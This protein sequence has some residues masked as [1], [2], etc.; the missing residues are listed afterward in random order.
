MC[1]PR[2][3]FLQCNHCFLMSWVEM[4]HSL[5]C[6]HR[7]FVTARRNQQLAELDEPVEV[8][9]IHREHVDD[10]RERVLHAPCTHLEIRESEGRFAVAW[11]EFQRCT[12]LR[13]RFVHF[14][15]GCQDTAEL[16]TRTDREFIQAH[17]LT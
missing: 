5:V 4:Q 7:L 11:Q 3:H 2:L 6:E 12:K 8:V 9:R 13:G 10:D 15:R 16:D 1:K 17:G 14:S